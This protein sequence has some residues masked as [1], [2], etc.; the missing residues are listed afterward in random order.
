MDGA[1]FGIKLNDSTT[2]LAAAGGGGGGSGAGACN[3]TIE[4]HGGVNQDKLT[5][6][7]LGQVKDWTGNNYNTA[8]STSGANGVKWNEPIEAAGDHQATTYGMASRRRRRRLS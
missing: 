4:G 5:T 1:G 7:S 3:D 8:T 6:N 2:P